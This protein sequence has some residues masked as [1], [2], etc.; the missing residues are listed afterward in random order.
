MKLKIRNGQVVQEGFDGEMG[1]TGGTHYDVR[2][3]ALT[4]GVLKHNK[5]VEMEQ[6]LKNMAY[7]KEL[8]IKRK[9][10]AAE[11]HAK[12]KIQAETKKRQ[13]AYKMAQTKFVAEAFNKALK[14]NKH[15]LAKSAYLAGS[16][17]SLVKNPLA[18][19]GSDEGV[20][21]HQGPTHKVKAD[22]DMQKIERVAPSN[23]TELTSFYRNEKSEL[24]QYRVEKAVAKKSL[25]GQGAFPQVPATRTYVTVSA[26]P[27][28]Q[29][30]DYYYDQAMGCW[31]CCIKVPTISQVARAV[32]RPFEEVA[33]AVTG[34][35]QHI[36]NQIAN[37]K[38]P[39]LSLP[40]IRIPPIGEVVEGISKAAGNLLNSDLNP[41]KLFERTMKNTP[42]LKDIWR[43]V[44]SFTGGLLTSATNLNNLPSRALR[45][46]GISQAEIMDAAS[47]ALKAGLLVVSGP[48]GSVAFNAAL[49][50]TAAGQLKKGPLGQTELGRALLSVGEVA[51]IAYAAGSAVSNV[52]AQKVKEEATDRLTQEAAKKA[53]A[54][55]AIL[56]VAATGKVA[57]PNSSFV[58]SAMNAAQDEAKKAAIVEIQKKTGIP[59]TLATQM[60]EGKVPTQDQLQKEIIDH[61]KAQA[62]SEFEKKTGVPVTVAQQIAQGRVPSMNEIKEKAYTNLN[63]APE[64]LK[65]QLKNVEAQIQAAPATIKTVLEEKKKALTETIAHRETLVEQARVEGAAKMG[66]A[67]QKI[68]DTL[69]EADKL[70]LTQKELKDK[71]TELQARA[72]ATA[73]E[74]LKEELSKQAE[75]LLQQLMGLDPG[76]KQAEQNAKDAIREASELQEE[77]GFKEAA[78]EHGAKDPQRK[79]GMSVGAA[80]GI[81]AAA[82]G[83]GLLLV[84]ES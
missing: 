49:I 56:A 18:G 64:I 27:M 51:G 40:Q 65:E 33:K 43:D 46:E 11:I 48:V 41:V 62:A 70:R 42:V 20:V 16:K 45:G 50:G 1:A 10:H 76:R 71:A 78:I 39:N 60:V 5:K 82:A 3:D 75:L 84:S 29:F 21:Y 19:F 15:A 55:G 81:G 53:G 35:I 12:R 67:R 32:T 59:V 2:L 7:Q 47:F 9:I 80:L 52:A 31:C 63:Y 37:I 6:A 23:N 34:S 4:N 22:F 44:D 79:F 54:A 58:T 14:E 61:A 57:D 74:K 26:H 28:A 72:M 77:L 8:E 68:D 66:E 38:L 36:G 25:P 13:D 83:V 24:N 69:K 17:Q 73:N 30:S